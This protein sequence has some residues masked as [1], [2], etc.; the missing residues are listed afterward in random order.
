MPK[1]SNFEIDGQEFIAYPFPEYQEYMGEEWF[2]D[3]CYYC[4]DCDIYFIPKERCK[5][6]E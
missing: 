2:R 6:T 5:S 1:K 3:E 4:A